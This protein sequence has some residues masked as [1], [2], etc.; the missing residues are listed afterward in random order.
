MEL[1]IFRIILG[2]DELRGCLEIRRRLQKTQVSLRNIN[3][4]IAM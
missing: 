1:P 2:T 3:R 4:I